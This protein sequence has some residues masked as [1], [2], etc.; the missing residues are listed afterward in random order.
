MSKKKEPR[1][2]KPPAYLRKLVVTEVPAHSVR[3]NPYNPNIQQLSEFKLLLKSM[4]DEGLTSP[5]LA[6]RIDGSHHAADPKLKNYPVGTTVIVDGEHR[7]RAWAVLNYLMRRGEWKNGSP[8]NDAVTDARSRAPK[9]LAD[10]LNDLTVPVVYVPLDPA[11][12][13][14]ATLRHNRSRGYEDQD[15]LASLFKDL[16]SLD[17]SGWAAKALM[18]AESEMKAAAGTASEML[19]SDVITEAWEPAEEKPAKGAD[20]KEKKTRR[21]SETPE[22]K[23]AITTG[24]G[25]KDLFRLDLVYHGEQ[26]E[27]VQAALGADPAVRILRWCADALADGPASGP[28]GDVETSGG[29]DGGEGD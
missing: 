17:S 9:I 1:E 26:A 11:Q 5:V 28:T 22:A 24:V 29:E 20:A 8:E 16:E 7:W 6:V 13:R 3:P 19:S 23:E 27:T 21:V 25:K 18:M 14:V 10:E 12:M 2:D 4:N 15:A